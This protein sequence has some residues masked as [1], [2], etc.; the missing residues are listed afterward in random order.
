[1]GE[2]GA[3]L[4]VTG[5]Q[6]AGASWR[7]SEACKGKETGE[8]GGDSYLFSFPHWTPPPPLN[9]QFSWQKPPLFLWFP[10]TPTPV[11]N[12]TRCPGS[13]SLKVGGKHSLQVATLPTR[14]ILTQSFFRLLRR[15]LRTDCC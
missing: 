1:V 9:L 5:R 3:I 2:S 6:G 4:D 7:R 12:C 8:L 15:L 14:S 13:Q 10:T 11:G